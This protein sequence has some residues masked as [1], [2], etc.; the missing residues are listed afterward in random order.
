MRKYT[1]YAIGEIALVVIGILIAL[2]ISNWNE[3]RISSEKEELLLKELHN[4]FL[5]NKK[6]LEQVLNAHQT[7]L[8]ACDKI[9]E[10]F[11]IDLKQVD[12]DSLEL[13]MSNSLYHWTFNPSQGVI[14][15]LVSTSSFELILDDS[16]RRTIIRWSD[17]LRDYQEEE[18]K[19]LRYFEGDFI[20]YWE[21][22]FDFYINLEDGR[23]NLAAL[24]TLQFEN[25]IKHRR[26]NLDAIIHDGELEI[27]RSMIDRIITLTEP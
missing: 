21:A 11:P 7:G 8:N 15:S 19:S 13:Y 6:Q 12:L 25:K 4:E 3:K 16:L 23:N 22:N 17:V 9:I 24:S 14:N 5:D 27:I 1:I 10:M 18:I 26:F 20:R 2:Q